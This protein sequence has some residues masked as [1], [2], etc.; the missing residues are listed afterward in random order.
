MRKGMNLNRRFSTANTFLRAHRESAARLAEVAACTPTP[1]RKEAT[2][3]ASAA[4]PPIGLTPSAS[5]ADPHP[6][7]PDPPSSS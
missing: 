1:V 3:K 6:P 4:T 5:A 7:S 2:G